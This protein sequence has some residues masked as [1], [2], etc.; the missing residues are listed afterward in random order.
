MASKRHK[1]LQQHAKTEDRQLKG[2]YYTPLYVVDKAY[3]KLSEILGK[4]WQETYVIWDMCCGVGNLEVK[5]CNHRNIYMSTLDQNDIDI[6]KATE[7]CVAS[8]KF[9]YDYLNDDITKDGTIDY[10]LSDKMPDGLRKAIA[11]GKKLLVLINPPYVAATNASNTSAS[12]KGEET[13]VKIGVSKTRFSEYCM[14]EYSR[15]KTEVFVQFLARITK[16]MPNSTIAMFSKMKYV[17]AP[18]MQGVRDNWNAKY[19]GGFVVHS[20]AFDGLKGDF[21]IGFLV[22]KNAQNSKKKRPI[23]EISIEVIDKNA[24]PIGKKKFYNLQESDLLNS[25]VKRPK[26]SNIKCI[27]LKNAVS[28]ATATKDIRGTKWHDDFIASFNCPGNDFQASNSTCITSSGFSSAGAFFV[29]KGNLWKVAIMFSVRRLIKQTWLN[30]T[31]QFLQPTEEITEEFKNDCLIW[32]LFNN[33]NLTASANNLEW[34][35][36]KWDIVNHFIPFTEDEVNASTRFESDFMVQ[37]LKNKKLS[38]EAK[39]VLDEGR[40]IWQA[41][42]TEADTHLIRE[43][44]KLNRA[45]VGWYQIRNALKKRCANNEYFNA[46]FAGFDDFKN[47]YSILSDKLRPQVFELG[48]LK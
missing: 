2:A 15:A 7:T 45:D 12:K 35:N 24:V 25:W 13:S 34:N 20:K 11:D 22:W 16:E 23:T 43:E 26:P 19:L 32:M 29:T 4:N 3:D 38:P 36:K 40:K 1:K 8:Q 6:M 47:A 5:H 28:P 27:P 9:Q 17:T 10:S 41:Y 31:D 21:P 18:A 30:D 33:S 42:F 44:L 48:F 14:Q 37:Y 39:A 46:I